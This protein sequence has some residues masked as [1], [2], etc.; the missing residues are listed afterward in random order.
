MAGFR[1]IAEGGRTGNENIAMISDLFAF[2][3]LGAYVADVSLA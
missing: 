3:V 2:L 1:H